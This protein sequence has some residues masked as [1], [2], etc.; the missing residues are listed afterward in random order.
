M[1]QLPGDGTLKAAL[2]WLQAL[3]TEDVPRVRALFTH[4]DEYADLTPDQYAQ[5]LLWLHQVG[6]AALPRQSVPASSLES[7]ALGH[8]LLAKSLELARPEWATDT[9][10]PAEGLGDLPA[11][12]IP[13]AESLGLSHSEAAAVVAQIRLEERAR[14]G[15]AGEAALLALLRAN[16]N[17]DVTHVSAISD[18]FGYDISVTGPSGG[19][20][21][22]E[23]KTTTSATSRVFF[24]SRHEYETM[25]RD[26]AWTLAV[27][28]LGQ[29]NRAA[30]VSTASRAWI[31][32][33]V[34]AD[35]EAGTRWE[36]ARLT[37]PP[38]AAETG[39]PAVRPWLS[40]GCEVELS[41]P[42]G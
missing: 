35:R 5:G 38:G 34:P 18:R 8:L 40:P 29:D 32:D 41:A 28:V 19:E 25:R 14:V 4:H 6:M 24:L 42:V 16:L 20:A 1:L 36:S 21:H 10:L 37:I 26:P 17:A 13:V 11:A 2:R 27:V 22:I 9:G 39:I 7:Q 15:A 3:R 12:A 31:A 33:A 23:V 30:S